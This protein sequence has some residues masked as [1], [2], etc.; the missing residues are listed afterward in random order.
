MST[1]LIGIYSPAPQSGKTF[2]ATVLAHRGYQPVSFAEPLKRMITEFLISFG[3]EKDQAIKLAWFDKTVVIQEFNASSRYLLQTL[4]TQWGRDCVCEDIW[5]RAWKA[6]V[7]KFDRVIVDDVRFPNE[8]EW[9]QSQ[10]GVVIEVQRGQNPIWYQ[11]LVDNYDD[12]DFKYNLMDMFK[13]H[14]SEWAWVG[15]KTK[16]LLSNHGTKEELVD[17]V[18]ILLTKL[19]NRDNV[20]NPNYEG[21]T[22]EVI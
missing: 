16:G 1:R 5:I 4:G 3:Y 7:A 6:R 14:E 13:V 20:T 8:I 11:E 18:N 2:A 22:N 21:V 9:I 12:Y 15:T 19:K 10:D 17:N